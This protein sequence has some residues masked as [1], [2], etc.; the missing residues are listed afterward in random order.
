MSENKNLAVISHKSNLPAIIDDG[1]LHSYLEQIKKFPVLSEAEETKLITDFKENGNLQSAQ[2][3]I[4]SHLRLAAKI[5]LTYRS[6][7][8]PMSDII[9]E[10]H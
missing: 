5:A 7:G 6:Y 10:A 9:S 3:L 2:K 1:G 4:T 8:L